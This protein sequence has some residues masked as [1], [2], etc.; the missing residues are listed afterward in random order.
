MTAASPETGARRRVGPALAAA[1]AGLALAALPVGG[2]GDSGRPTGS[3]YDRSFMSR[4][5]QDGGRA[6]YCS[7]VLADTKALAAEAGVPPHPFSPA[8]ARA[9]G[10]NSRCR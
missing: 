4:C 2:C 9:T 10:A 3:T 7:C 6:A 1:L 8:E 5:D